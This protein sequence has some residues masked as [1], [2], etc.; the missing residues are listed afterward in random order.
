MISCLGVFFPLSPAHQD[1]ALSCAPWDAP[2]LF[3]FLVT[4]LKHRILK[5]LLK[6]A[7]SE[8]TLQLLARHN[9]LSN[10]IRFIPNAITCLFS[11]KGFSDFCWTPSYNCPCL[12]NKLP[13]NITL[14]IIVSYCVI[15]T[16]KQMCDCER[17]HHRGLCV[18]CC[19]LPEQ[20]A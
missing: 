1:C 5:W 11:L 4:R 10:R 3:W 2:R 13:L 12:W 8:G 14:R 18:Q 6:Q 19:L 7:V 9:I 17:S 15:P 16:L 20:S